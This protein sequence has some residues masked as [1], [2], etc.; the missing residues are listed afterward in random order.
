MKKQF[1][2]GV[3]VSF[4]ISA[5]SFSAEIGTRTYSATF[6]VGGTREAYVIGLTYDEVDQIVPGSMDFLKIV[7]V[8]YVRPSADKTCATIT[9][10]NMLAY[11]GWGDVNGFKTSDDIYSFAMS[12]RIAGR[13]AN[14]SYICRWFLSGKYDY[15]TPPFHSFNGFYPDVNSKNVLQY[16]DGRHIPSIVRLMKQGHAVSMGVNWGA[17]RGHGSALFGVV[18]DT[19]KNSTSRDYYVGVIIA[20]SYDHVGD[21]KLCYIPMKWDSSKQTYELNYRKSIGKHVFNIYQNPIPM[22]TNAIFLDTLYVMAP[23]SDYKK[24]LIANHT[25]I[26]YKPVIETASA[27]IIPDVQIQTQSVLVQAVEE[28]KQYVQSVQEAPIIVEPKVI[29]E[30]TIKPT[31]SQITAPVVYQTETVIDNVTDNTSMGW[32]VIV[33]IILIGVVSVG[34][35]SWLLKEIV[36]GLR[37]AQ[38]A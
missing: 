13:G 5:V 7:K 17:E 19:S 9:A 36:Q 3:I 18:Y 12:K 6:N 24:R 22:P 30:P 27:K 2:F 15:H 25:R 26:D 23:R 32:V 33:A 14:D 34:C 29:T 31:V 4:A 8:F 11:S 35:I 10:S 28:P 21:Q 38:N 37:N 16:F 20:D 1:I